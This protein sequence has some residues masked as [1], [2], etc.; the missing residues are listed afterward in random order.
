MKADNRMSA[1][2]ELL[3]WISEEGSGSWERLRD[4]SAH[5]CQK[6]D[7]RWRPWQ[8]ATELSALGHLDID[9][10]TREWSVAPPALNLIPGMG[11]WIVLTGS[12]PY[13]VDERF[14]EATELQKVFPLPVPQPPAPAAKLAKCASVEVAELVATRLGAELVFDPAKALVGGMRAV[15]EM[16]MERAPA[17]SWEQAVRFNAQS[18]RWEE[19]HDESSGLYRVDLH[20]RPVHRRLDGH[21]LWWTIDL[22]AGQFLELQNRRPSVLQWRPGTRDAAPRF[23]VRTGIALPTLAERAVRVCS[24]FRPRVT[25]EWR[26]Y[27]NVPEYIAH[28]IAGRLLHEIPTVWRED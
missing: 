7:L 26:S 8:L 14:D 4:A 15:D 18:L 1:G 27:V 21:G 24:G 17:P 22:P 16:P 11:L 6:H 28:T 23:E 20:G 10:S 3:R 5:V 19:D 13:Y 25:S 12:R 9:W 2:D